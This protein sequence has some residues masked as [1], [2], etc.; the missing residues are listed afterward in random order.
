MNNETWSDNIIK[1]NDPTFK[2]RW[3]VYKKDLTKL[4]DKDSIWI[5]C[6][7]GNNEM[8]ETYK[9]SRDMLSV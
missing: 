4:L 8:V 5:D 3:V 2:H 7:C 1:K 9:N 6:G